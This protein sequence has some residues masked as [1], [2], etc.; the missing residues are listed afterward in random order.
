MS[1]S[2]AGSAS[3]TTTTVL[4]SDLGHVDLWLAAVKRHPKAVL[5][6]CEGDHDV[7]LF[8]IVD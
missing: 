4:H 1:E 7:M 6:H 3:M 8:R 2:E 5:Q